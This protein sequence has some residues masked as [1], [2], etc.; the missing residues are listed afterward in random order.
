MGL[1]DWLFG[2]PPSPDAP[3]P[4]GPTGLHP[5][6]IAHGRGFTFEIV[7][8]SH[9]QEA[10]DDICGG[11]CEDGHKLQTTAELCFVEDNPY[12]PHAVGVFI[13]AR[14]VGYVPRELAKQFRSEILRINPE[15]RP[16]TCDAKIVGGWDRGDG[17]EGHYGVKLNLSKPLR[18]KR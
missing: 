4:V 16:V 8:E 11:K 10:L 9:R 18:L 12:D 17:D 1:L 2:T 7:G 15:Q 3:R 6:H 5:V 14:L 13:H